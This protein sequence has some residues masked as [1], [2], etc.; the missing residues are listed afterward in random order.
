[1]QHRQLRSHPLEERLQPLQIL[2]DLLLLGGLGLPVLVE[3]EGESERADARGGD[4][5]VQLTDGEDG[6]RSPEA[7]KRRRAHLEDVGRG[8]GINVAGDVEGLKVRQLG[9]ES[10][11]VLH[12]AR[13]AVDERAELLGLLTDESGKLDATGVGGE[14]GG[15]ATAAV[16]RAG[17]RAVRGEGEG[18]EVRRE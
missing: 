11:D 6:G 12:G 1:M 13:S 10:S 5:S 2:G 7:T 8:R 18:G 9:S 3:I 4:E 15:F 14:G 16:G 17:Y